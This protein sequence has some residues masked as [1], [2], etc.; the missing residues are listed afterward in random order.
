MKLKINAMRKKTIKKTG[1]NCIFVLLY[2]K[3]NLKTIF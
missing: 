2:K 1:K 3:T